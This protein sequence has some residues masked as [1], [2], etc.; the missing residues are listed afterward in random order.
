MNSELFA[1]VETQTPVASY[2]VKLENFEGPLDLLLHLIRKEEID[3]Y[4]IPIA[5]ITG[6]YLE[7]IQVMENLDLELAGEFILMAATLIR[8][9][10]KMLLPAQPDEEED[11]R[12]ELVQALLEHQK[13]QKV[14]EEL[15]ARE[16]EASLYHPRLDFSSL[17]IPDPVVEFKVPSLYELLN[18]YKVLLERQTQKAIHEIKLPEVTLEERIERVMTYLED[19]GKVEFEELYLDIPLK[20]YMVVTLLAAL[21]LV[22]RGWVKLEQ[23]ELFGTIR[24]WRIRN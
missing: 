18:T 16:K 17:A 10:T 5:K 9:K 23:K 15:S 1:D 8:I 3:I 20:I 6:Q 12:A 11:P 21:E 22:R 7:Y 4:D 13:F 14:G 24:L 19:R 2:S